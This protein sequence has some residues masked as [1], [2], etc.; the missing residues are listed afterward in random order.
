MQNGPFQNDTYCWVAC[1]LQAD[2]QSEQISS[3][4]VYLLQTP[5]GGS[6]T[7]TR[8]ET[9]RSRAATTWLTWSAP[10]TPS[11]SWVWYCQTHACTHTHATHMQINTH[12][13]THTHAHTHV[14]HTPACICA[15]THIHI[16]TPACA[17]TPTHTLK[18]THW[19]IHK[20]R[21]G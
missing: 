13:H 20:N 18:H 19:E 4:L 6:D 5:R 21:K 14:V 17:H 2:D 3:W 15:H 10:A 9:W 7:P 12:T 11:P 1:G 8:G 16:H